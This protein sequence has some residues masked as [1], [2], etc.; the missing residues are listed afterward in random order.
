MALLSKDSPVSY[1]KTIQIRLYRPTNFY[2]LRPSISSLSDRPVFSKTVLFNSLDRPVFVLCIILDDSSTPQFQTV[3]FRRPV[4][5]TIHFD[6]RPFTF[7]L[8]QNGRYQIS[9]VSS[10]S[11]CYK[12]A[13]F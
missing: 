5:W 13:D 12:N 3:H 7:D 2:V 9:S 6:S 4:N 11:Y 8:T 1:K 10:V